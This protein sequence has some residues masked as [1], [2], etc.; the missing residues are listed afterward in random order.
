V[1]PEK[2]GTLFAL[3]GEVPDAPAISAEALRAHDAAVRRIAESCEA[4]LPARFDS[5]VE[6]PGSGAARS[7]DLADIRA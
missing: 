6:S 3:V 1:R 7:L 5:V 4:F 2:V